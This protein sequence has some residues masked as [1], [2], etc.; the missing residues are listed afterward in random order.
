LANTDA[1]EMHYTLAIDALKDIPEGSALEVQ[2][3]NPMG[4]APLV[5][6]QSVDPSRAH[7]HFQS[8]PVHGHKV[9]NVYQM[10]VLLYSDASHS[11]HI[12]RRCRLRA[13]PEPAIGRIPTIL[14]ANQAST[15]SRRK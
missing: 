8:P 15:L 12:A 2:F 10:E 7:F 6:T 9:G 1:K 13:A 3:E 4:G 5:T 11:Q 14:S